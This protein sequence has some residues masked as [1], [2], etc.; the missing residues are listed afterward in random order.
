MSVHHDKKNTSHLVQLAP[1]LLLHVAAFLSIEDI[2]SLSL[3]CGTLHS[4]LTRRPLLYTPLLLSPYAD[5][6][7]S[8]VLFSVMRCHSNTQGYIEEL[9]L[10]GCH[11]LSSE[12]I[13]HLAKRYPGLTSLDVSV[14]P[15]HGRMIPGKHREGVYKDWRK[16][17]SFTTNRPPWRLS[18]NAIQNLTQ[19]S[20]RNL[21]LA[22]H[23]LNALTA[24]AISG[25][26]SLTSLDISGCTWQLSQ[27]DL[28]TIVRGLGDN[29]IELRI[30]GFEPTELT[31]LC[32][33]QH[34]KNLN[35]LHLSGGKPAILSKFA[36]NLPAL[37]SLRNLRVNQIQ[38]GNVD[39]L[40]QQLHPDTTSLDLSAKMDVYASRGRGLRVE[41]PLN[42][43]SNGLEAL[44]NLG[45]LTVLRLSNLMWMSK[46]T[47]SSLLRNL[48]QLQAFE[49]R[50]WPD[51]DASDGRCA[52]VVP[53]L[54]PSIVPD[55]MEITLV[56]VTLSQNTLLAWTKFKN[57]RRV[58]ISDIGS[59]AGSGEGFLRQWLLDIDSLEAVR[60]TKCG[61]QWEQVAD[62]VRMKDAE[63]DDADDRTD[64]SI[65]ELVGSMC[66]EDEVVIIKGRKGWE[67]R[68]L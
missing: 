19:C 7:T 12:S 55:L 36:S 44:Q 1:E 40:I 53:S 37:K 51:L 54:V 56:G 41:S 25:M 60:I 6:I 59:E 43:T 48:P 15:R 9:D 5:K 29:L 65:D 18:N 16:S 30:L 67:W 46:E 49:L 68:W 42:M 32:L 28:Q 21:S 26:K 2:L 50:M 10:S 62:L 11:Q 23:D 47:A 22:G 64:C 24:I 66:Y 34:C 35:L 14:H 52:D 20:L 31:L 61:I 45:S 27:A 17:S 63:S 33:R 13:I 8:K 39:T 58:E 57:L 3:T 4:V 38:G